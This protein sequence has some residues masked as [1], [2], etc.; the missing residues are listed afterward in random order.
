MAKDTKLV[1]WMKSN[2]KYPCLTEMLLEAISRMP[3]VA[4]ER[5]SAADE[6]GD[7]AYNWRSD[8]LLTT[9]DV[10]T[11]LLIYNTANGQLDASVFWDVNDSWKIGLQGTNLNNNVTE[12]LMQV[13]EAGDKKTR[14]WFTND[15]RYSLVVR[16]TF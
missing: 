4:I 12:A 5:F 14:S 16:A 9:G 3:S 8:C 11:K 7:I 1:H 2:K 13:N 6:A 10:I 15:R